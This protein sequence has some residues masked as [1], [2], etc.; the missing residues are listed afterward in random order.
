[1]KPYYQSL[2]QYLTEILYGHIYD[3]C[4]NFDEYAIILRSHELQQLVLSLS[5]QYNP[6][7]ILEIAKS[8]CDL[9]GQT[10]DT[11][12][13]RNL[14]YY[15]YEVLFDK[16]EEERDKILEDVKCV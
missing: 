5:K 4:F 1:M 7:E 6:M 16:L 14:I 3:S 9:A 15:I 12:N 8:A 11:I 10:L 13:D 2:D